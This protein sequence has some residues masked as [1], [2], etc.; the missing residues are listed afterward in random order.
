MLPWSQAVITTTKFPDNRR[1]VDGF[2]RSGSQGY[3]GEKGRE[4]GYFSDPARHAIS[5]S[6]SASAPFPSAAWNQADSGIGSHSKIDQQ[7]QHHVTCIIAVEG[8]G[9]LQKYGLSSLFSPKMDAYKDMPTASY[10]EFGPSSV[11][12]TNHSLEKTP[13]PLGLPLSEACS[14]ERKSAEG[15]ELLA[16]TTSPGP[17]PRMISEYHQALKDFEKTT[18]PSHSRFCDQLEVES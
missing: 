18:R 4:L 17:T 12:E 7:N 11:A 1:H 14:P 6:H 5:V 10:A 15:P 8:F 16:I 9:T 3:Q 2:S 13:I